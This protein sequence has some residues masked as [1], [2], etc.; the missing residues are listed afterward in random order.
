MTA[1][2]SHQWYICTPIKDNRTYENRVA[3]STVAMALVTHNI[4]PMYVT[5]P[6]IAQI[7]CTIYHI[8]IILNQKVYSY[9]KC[10]II[11][12]PF[13]FNTFIFIRI[14]IYNF[15]YEISCIMMFI[16]SKMKG[17]S[18]FVRKIENYLPLYNPNNIQYKEQ[19]YNIKNSIR[20][21]NNISLVFS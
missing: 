7:M 9:N 19:Y 11:F 13:Y 8:V 6:K 3:D 2:D 18:S 20:R 21:K 10:N 4:F 15:F 16:W 12:I 14:F 5:G 17:T 1:Y